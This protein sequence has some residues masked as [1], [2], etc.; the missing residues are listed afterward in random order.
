MSADAATLSIIIPTWNRCDLVRSCLDSLAKQTWRGFHVIVVDDASEDDTA[1]TLA[2]DYPHV[3]LVRLRKRSGFA[4]AT[5]SGLRGAR[6]PWMLCLNNDITLAPD[7]LDHLMAAAQVGGTHILTPLMLWQDTPQIVYAAGD[8]LRV[9]GRPESHGFRVPREAFHPR[10]E[11]FGVTFG[12][13]LIS[14]EA[15]H[16]VGDLDTS[17]GAYFEDADW[18]CRARLLG[19][20]A[21]CVPEAVV[22]HVGSA[23]IQKALWWRARQCWQ[24]HAL[25]VV[26]NFPASLLLRFAPAIL[27]ERLHQT[28][29]FLSAAR[30]ARGTIWAL[31]V[32][33]LAQ[34]ELWARLPGALVERQAIQGA[35]T[36]SPGAFAE[37]LEREDHHD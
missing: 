28:R 9:S 31:R 25:L 26:K 7:A 14:R 10:A 2:R 15:L 8:F 18:C 4:H 30:A 5:N 3:E 12:A 20:D 19:Y 23:S 11:V 36:T 34:L 37:W 16:A 6:T 21:R 27:R 22:Y 33:I 32:F 13:A 29:R 17:F 24:N 35:R 1:D